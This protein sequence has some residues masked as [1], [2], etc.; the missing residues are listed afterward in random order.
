MTLAYG[1][2]IETRMAELTGVLGPEA[3]AKGGRAA[4]GIW[5]LT[6]D[7]R[8]AG[9][10]GPIITSSAHDFE[11][12]RVALQE[13]MVFIYKPASMTPNKSHICTWG[14]TVVVTPAGGRRLGSRPHG[15]AIAGI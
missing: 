1:E 2:P 15:L 4:G 5:P 14:D 11:Q 9:D 8:G 10:D 13:N 12:L 6:M 7:G 3:A